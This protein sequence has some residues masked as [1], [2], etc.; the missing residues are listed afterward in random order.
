MTILILGCEND[1][2]IKH[3]IRKLTQLD[4]GILHIDYM[5]ELANLNYTF[6]EN[7]I[8]NQSISAIYWRPPEIKASND[9]LY[10]IKDICKQQEA[11]NIIFP[12]D[13]V[14]PVKCINPMLDNLKMENKIFQLN[15]ARLCNLKIPK[16]LISCNK[17]K[18]I[19][20]CNS[21]PVCIEKNLGY[22]WDDENK[23]SSTRIFNQDNFHT[24][25]NLPCIYQEKINRKHEIRLYIIGKT[26][27]A[28]KIN[29]DSK[30]SHIP[31]W[32]LCPQDYQEGQVKQS[33]L[34]GIFEFH[35]RTNL[36]YAAYDIIVDSNDN[37]Y[38]IECNPC[39]YWN[40]LP[41]SFSETITSAICH[42]LTTHKEDL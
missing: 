8:E 28:V 10:T 3:V 20:F 24:L 31:D 4:V 26:H 18:I 30:N 39:G 19:K 13:T 14:F 34:T 9:T 23:P 7:A 36:V 11:W 32:R 12:V 2:Q 16:T 22:H 17:E 6:P 33:T 25:S 35:K 15:L 42:E 41:D 37:E 40:F 1:P 38:F 27:L 29:I 5:K 21:V